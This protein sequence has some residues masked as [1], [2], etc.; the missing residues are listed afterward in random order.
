MKI[1]Y[2][3]LAHRNPPQVARM[4]R[5]LSH[6]G[7]SFFIHID[8]KVAIEPFVTAVREMG[9][10]PYFVPD[11]EDVLWGGY[12]MVQATINA[13]SAALSA[14]PHDYYILLSG[15]DY[16]IRSADALMAELGSGRHEY[17]NRHRMP[18]DHVGKPISRLQ[19]PYRATRD[20]RRPQAR[21]IN[22]LLRLLPKQDYKKVLGELEPHGGSQ[23]WCFSEPCIRYIMGF[24]ESRPEFVDF[25]RT[26]KIP[27]EIMFHTILSKSPFED[28][29]K[30]ALT[31]TTWERR[32]M[33]PRTLTAAHLPQLRD[34]GR[35]FARKFDLDT[36]PGI[37]DLIDTQLRRDTS[38]TRG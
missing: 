35:F 8:R 25:F 13:V 36:D 27:D 30:P 38:G 3:I 7:A 20:P 32:G 31:F 1:A 10:D 23:W 28:R 37:F 17:V 26:V 19:H 14:G 18:A 4:L 21:I 12:S 33:S 5:A 24:I 16:P 9:L 11:R 6:D 2:I 15:A 34:C 29:I 22:G